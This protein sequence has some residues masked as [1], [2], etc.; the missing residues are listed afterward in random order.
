MAPKGMTSHS[1]MERLERTQKLIRLYRSNECL[2]NPKSPG[3]HSDSVKEDAWQWITR[4]MKCGLTPDQ[5]KLQVF[6]LRNYYS[7]ECAAIRLSQRKGF[8][9]APRHSYFEDLQFLGNL[10]FEESK[11]CKASFSQLNCLLE[12][13][14]VLDDCSSIKANYHPAFSEATFCE[15]EAYLTHCSSGYTIYNMILEPEPDQEE[16]IRSY[17]E[18]ATSGNDRWYPTTYCV[19]CNQNEGEDGHS[20]GRGQTL[21][22]R[23]GSRSSLEGGK[24]P[25]T[26]SHDQTQ[27]HLETVIQNRNGNP[28]HQIEAES[29]YTPESQSESGS[30]QKRS[31]NLKH[32][33]VE[34]PSSSTNRQKTS[35]RTQQNGVFVDMGNWD[36][37]ESTN[38]VVPSDNWPGPRLCGQHRQK[39]V[40]RGRKEVPDGRKSGSGRWKRNN[41][42]ICRRLQ[43]RLAKQENPHGSYFEEGDSD[44]D[45]NCSYKH[46]DRRES[47]EDQLNVL[48]LKKNG[49]QNDSARNNNNEPISD[50]GNYNSN[51]PVEN[52]C[53]CSYYQSN[54]NPQ[55]CEIYGCQCMYCNRSLAPAQANYYPPQQFDQNAT[56]FGQTCPPPNQAYEEMENEYGRGAYANQPIVYCIN[57][58][59]PNV[60]IPAQS[61]CCAPSP[62]QMPMVPL[63]G[64]G[65]SPSTY[66]SNVHSKCQPESPIEN[67]EFV[68]CPAFKKEP[69]SKDQRERSNRGNYQTQD[70]A[71]NLNEDSLASLENPI[72]DEHAH[73]R[74]MRNDLQ[75][76]H[77]KVI[78]Q[79][80]SFNKYG[81]YPARGRRRD[82]NDEKPP[83]KIRDGQP[84]MTKRCDDVRCPANRHYP[85]EERPSQRRP[86]NDDMVVSY[87][88]SNYED[89]TPPRPRR[90]RTE[91]PNHSKV[92]QLQTDDSQKI[93]CSAYDR[94]NP[95]ED[96]N[97]MRTRPSTRNRD[98]EEEEKP[99]S[100]SKS[101]GQETNHPD[102]GYYNEPKL[103]PK[104]R[105][106]DQS[107]EDNVKPK[108]KSEEE[109]SNSK[110]RNQAN[111]NDETCPFG[112]YKLRQDKD[113]TGRQAINAQ[114]IINSKVEN[115]KYKRSRR[116][117]YECNDDTCPYAAFAGVHKERLRKS[118]Q[119]RGEDEMLP[120]RRYRSEPTNKT[121]DH[122]KAKNEFESFGNAGNKAPDDCDDCECD[123]DDN[124]YQTKEYR[125]DNLDYD[126]SPEDG[127]PA[128]RISKYSRREEKNVP[129]KNNERT[130]RE[131]RNEN[132]YR[133][134]G[135]T[136]M[137]CRCDYTDSDGYDASNAYNEYPL[138]ENRYRTHIESNGYD[139]AQ[140][141]RRD[142]RGK[143]YD[144]YSSE[145]EDQAYIKSDNQN[146]NRTR[147]KENLAVKKKPS[148]SRGPDILD[149]E[150][151]CFCSEYVFPETDSR[152]KDSAPNRK[153]QNDP[154]TLY[155]NEEKIQERTTGNIIDFD[156]SEDNRYEQ[157][158]NK[159]ENRSPESP[160]PKR[161]KNEKKISNAPG[162][163]DRRNS[164]DVGDPDEKKYSKS[165]DSNSNDNIYSDED[166]ICGPPSGPKEPKI[167]VSNQRKQAGS[168]CKVLNALME[169]EVQ[170]EESIGKVK[171]PPVQTNVKSNKIKVD[172]KE[173]STKPR[174]ALPLSSN[175]SQPSSVKNNPSP[176]IV[177]STK[178]QSRSASPIRHLVTPRT[179][180]GEPTKKAPATAKTGGPSS[181]KK[182]TMDTN[183]A[184]NRRR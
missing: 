166:C 44:Q 55:R 178:V 81:E 129:N 70:R 27:A 124:E 158:E 149:S 84:Q 171:K 119:E 38:N 45:Q 26:I 91:K 163:G 172:P 43:D 72:Y 8:S 17:K 21:I 31:E 176:K 141:N 73:R 47:G 53:Y 121:K 62:A 127:R 11:E 143:G 113:R 137:E 159:N 96:I 85:N 133:S 6:S 54:P 168:I 5:V 77:R 94:L 4:Q 48:L 33:H 75:K 34:Y 68:E 151:E 112:G 86:R 67:Y 99:S 175:D 63:S 154:P 162:T 173:V 150:Y 89:Y 76:R 82:Y 128:E 98:Y 24:N 61:A 114:E 37:E 130:P 103:S 157:F 12:D 116:K 152:Y 148:F 3:F 52:Q 104:T 101:Q 14:L 30:R 145:S 140:A 59:D 36:G 111:C 160:L 165:K 100:K 46:S 65:T 109:P 102:N 177:K 35:L 120:R 69:R 15:R 66:P 2:W 22:A 115:G 132:K 88:N 97:A 125:N 60:W 161:S 167:V 153:S 95:R 138:R 136:A 118:T 180:P 126:I 156:N 58:E 80:E 174:E 182:P 184:A 23:S 25:V 122:E 16:H 32:P 28:N 169:C 78:D 57:A 9:Y 19:Q 183:A 106:K 42:A 74:Q 144:Y 20:H 139:R 83:Q 107:R 155:N 56:N 79:E 87:P 108:K 41:D 170:K 18:R 164:N 117:D 1:K 123:S 29:P 134:I 7:K 64:N 10:D 146:N 50:Q 147:N 49:Q 179:Q 135:R 142:K 110:R 131:Y 51:Q 71:A 93:E 40:P 39:Y 90:D 105:T 92:Y 13:V 181:A